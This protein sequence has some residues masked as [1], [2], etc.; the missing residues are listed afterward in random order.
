MY[1]DAYLSAEHREEMTA[2]TSGGALGDIMA[3]YLE[4]EHGK[5]RFTRLYL[6]RPLFEDWI[7]FLVLYDVI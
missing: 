4:I 3:S 1:A 7:C 5:V 2:D 6:H